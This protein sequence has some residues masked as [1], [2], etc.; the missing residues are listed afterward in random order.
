MDE[1]V[2]TSRLS[3]EIVHYLEKDNLWFG[4][5]QADLIHLGARY[6]PCMRKDDNVYKAILGDRMKENSTACC[7]RN[8]ESHCV[9]TPASLCS[10]TLSTWLNSSYYSV[11]ENRKSGT[12]CGQ[13]PQFC[14][15]PASHAPYIWP[16][17]IIKWPICTTKS[18]IGAGAPEHMKCNIAGR[19]CCNGIQGECVIT[20]REHCAFVRGYFHEEA[21]LCAQIT[22]LSETCGMLPFR[23]PDRP[24]QFYRLWTS[25]FIHAG[26]LQ[27]FISVAFQMLITHKTRPD[28]THVGMRWSVLGFPWRELAVG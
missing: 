18:K 6:S 13:D 1:E 17:E 14:I 28:G 26:L 20:T 4:P 7:T 8:D 16:D 25:L 10:T 22:C 23:D 11:D 3:I 12:V 9:Q 21:T 5:R 19:P 27:L 2:L 15:A 24:D